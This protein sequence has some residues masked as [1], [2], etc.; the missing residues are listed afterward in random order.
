M[1]TSENPNGWHLPGRK[2]LPLQPD[3]NPAIGTDDNVDL[4]VSY[5]INLNLPETTDPNVFNAIFT[6]LRDNLLKK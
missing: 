6:A 4:R 3:A 2:L 1:V 5:T